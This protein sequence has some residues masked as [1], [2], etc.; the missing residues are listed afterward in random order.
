MSE[1]P[2]SILPP[3]VPGMLAQLKAHLHDSDQASRR[4]NYHTPAN[5]ELF[6]ILAKKWK[7]NDHKKFTID[8]GTFGIAGSSMRLK[9]THGLN[10]LADNT[11]GA[12]QQYWNH[13]RGR[14]RFKLDGNK[15]SVF[16]RTDIAEVVQ[17]VT[18]SDATALQ[19]SLERWVASDPRI[20]SR[21]PDGGEVELTPDAIKWFSRR[22]LELE[23]QNFVGIVDQRELQ[24][25]RVAPGTLK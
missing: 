13:I 11:K 5:G 10:W 22:M 3:Q 15:L 12:D 9:L 18:A 17:F 6:A 21:W 1:S 7:E 24:C 25:I 23:A 20:G 4:H 8:C 19:T 14:I 2:Q 16:L